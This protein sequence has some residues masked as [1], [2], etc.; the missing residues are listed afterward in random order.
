[1]TAEQRFTMPP[2]VPDDLL[3][4]L[5]SDHAGETGAVAI[6][7]GVLALTADPE[8][9]A[10]ARHHL[11]TEQLHLELMQQILPPRQR[12]RL[13]PLW[14]VAGWLLGAL[15][16]LIGAKAVY[17]TIDA[18]ESFVDAHYAAQIAKLEGRPVDYAL[19]R[20]LESCRQDEIEHRDDARRRLGAPRF[21]GRL[22][23]RIVWRGSALG[24]AVASRF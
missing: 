12:S 5:R 15:P 18:V 6:Y 22:W 21:A 8:V 1:M 3:R 7:R 13:L 2:T 20:V 9:R 16:A 17:R 24:V 11:A 10:F 19:R 23:R 14:R 4:D